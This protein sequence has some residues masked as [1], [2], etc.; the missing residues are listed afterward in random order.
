VP[1][2]L[3]PWT[4]DDVEIL[5]ALAREKVNTGVIAHKLKRT[6]GATRQQAKRAWGAAGGR[7]RKEE[8]GEISS[9]SEGYYIL[10]R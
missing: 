7:T 4:K 3:R 8:K 9:E 10:N 6:L 5:K 1:K 2:K